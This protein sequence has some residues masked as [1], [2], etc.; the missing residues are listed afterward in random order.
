MTWRNESPRPLRSCHRARNNPGSVVFDLGLPFVGINTNAT[1]MHAVSNLP[2]VGLVFVATVIPSALGLRQLLRD[3]EVARAR[4][5]AQSARPR[6]SRGAQ[7]LVFQRRKETTRQK[8]TLNGAVSVATMNGSGCAIRQLAQLHSQRADAVQGGGPE[9]AL[10]TPP[11]AFFAPM[12]HA[13][14]SNVSGCPRSFP[15]TW[16]TPAPGLDSINIKSL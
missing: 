2:L 11:A 10:Q 6:S 16:T 9:T 5:D 14:Q 8:T 4:A 7:V 1:A 15:C 3:M 13:L 12:H